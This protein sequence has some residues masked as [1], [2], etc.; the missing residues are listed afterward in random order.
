M[1]CIYCRRSSQR[2][3]VLYIFR[4]EVSI[5]DKL[6]L[7]RASLVHLYVLYTA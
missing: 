6:R 1:N 5:Y 3:L 2:L 7:R 4:L